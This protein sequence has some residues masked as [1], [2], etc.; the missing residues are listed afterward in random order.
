M[1]GNHYSRDT[2]N[3]QYLTGIIEGLSP[4]AWFLAAAQASY[5]TGG[6]GVHSYGTYLL[7]TTAISAWGK[8]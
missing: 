4:Q 6:F 5:H 1:T 8:H 2:D 7:T 3:T